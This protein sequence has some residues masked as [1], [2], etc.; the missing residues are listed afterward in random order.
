MAWLKGGLAK[1]S[2]ERRQHEVDHF[3]S[4]PHRVRGRG[5][6]RREQ[7]RLPSGSYEWVSGPSQT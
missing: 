2:S 1:F 7:K 4:P 3:P 6:G 5:G